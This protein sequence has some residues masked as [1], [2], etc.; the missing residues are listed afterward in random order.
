MTL[1]RTGQKVGSSIHAG[2]PSRHWLLIAPVLG[3][4][5]AGAAIT[6]AAQRLAVRRQ[7][8]AFGGAAIAFAASRATDGAT[9]SFFEGATLVSIGIGIADLVRSFWPR[10]ATE[11]AGRSTLD[12]GAPPRDATPVAEHPHHAQLPLTCA[13]GERPAEAAIAEAMACPD[14]GPVAEHRVPRARDGEGSGNPSTRR[15]ST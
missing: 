15:Y 11:P 9:R 3:A 4:A 13:E 5:G 10:P 8:V 7:A 6:V 12:G 1:D 14:E 2:T